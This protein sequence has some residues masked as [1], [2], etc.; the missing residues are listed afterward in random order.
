MQVQHNI[1]IKNPSKKILDL[2]AQIAKDKAAKQAA[3]ARLRL[4]GHN[5]GLS[6]NKG[7]QGIIRPCTNPKMLS[8]WKKTEK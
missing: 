4:Q 7:N 5:K 6:L 2:M 8:L 1:V 3:K